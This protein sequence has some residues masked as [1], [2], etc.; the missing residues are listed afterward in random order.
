MREVFTR[1][2]NPSFLSSLGGTRNILKPEKFYTTIIRLCLNHNYTLHHLSGKG[3]DINPICRCNT[4]SIA[5]SNHL[6]VDCNRYADGRDELWRANR[7]T[8]CPLPTYIQ[9]Y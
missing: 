5:D 8:S 7:Q 4:E 6:I 9:H 3:I 2:S 1:P